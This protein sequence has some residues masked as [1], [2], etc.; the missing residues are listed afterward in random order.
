MTHTFRNRSRLLG[1]CASAAVA[2][3]L[4]LAPERAAA[5]GIQASGNVVL[6]S[7]NIVDTGPT[8]TQVSL[9]TPTVVI[10]WTPTEDVN[11]DA[12]DFI[13][14]GST[15]IFRSNVTP[16]F[17]VLNRILPSTNNNVMTID[18]SVLSQFISAVGAAST[19]GLVAFSSPT[20]IVIGNNAVF[21]I[22]RLLLT[23]HDISNFWFQNFASGGNLLLNG[24]SGTTA[25]VQ[26][27]PGAQITAAPE[28]AFFAVV[29]ADI[30][31]SG[32]SQVNGSQAFVVGEVVNL[33]FSNGLFNISVPVGTSASGQVLTVNGTVGGP[34]STGVTGDNHMIYGVAHAAADPISMLFSGNLGFDTAASAG[35]INGEI[36]LAANYDVFGRS[37]AGGTISD[38]IGATFRFVD[39]SSNIRADILVQDFNS[40]SSLLAVGTHAVDATAE[41]AN[42]RVDGNLLLVGRESASLSG[43]F[44][45]DFTVTGD[46]L[47]DARDYGVVSSS[48][49][50]I[51][52]A[53]AQGGNASIEADFAG[54]ITITGNALVTADAFGGADDINRI[55]GSA[56][57]GNASIGAN[58]TG[59]VSIV[60]SAT[61]S[62][63][64]Q[65]T[66]AITVLQGALARGGSARLAS[67]LFGSVSVGGD[68]AI[69]ADALGANGSTVN[70]STASNAFGGTAEINV[71]DLSS[72]VIGGDAVLNADAVGGSS[73]N[74]GAGSIG[75]AGDAVFSVVG[76]AASALVGNVRLAVTGVA[77]KVELTA[78]AFGG[79]N[80]GGVGGLATGGTAIVLAADSGSIDFRGEFG[81]EALGV[82]GN[83]RTGGE[84]FGGIG[85]VLAASGSIDI[86][87]NA[88]ADAEG[89][90]GFASFGFGGIGGLGQ[91]GSAFFQANGNEIDAASLTIGGNAF[92]T[93]QGVGGRGGDTDGDGIPGGDGGVGRGG[94]ASVTNQANEGFVSGAYILADADYGTI[95][96]GGEAFT[97]AR[98]FGGEGGTGNLLNLGGRGGDGFGGDAALGVAVLIA[99][100]SI[101][102]GLAEFGTV[103]ARA[104]GLG[105]AGGGQN[106]SG[107]VNIGDGGTGTAG[108]AGL[109]ADVGTVNVLSTANATNVTLEAVGFGG[110]GRQG[111][112]AN[113]GTATIEGS[114]GG[115]ITATGVIIDARAIGG[116]SGLDDPG[117]A[118]GNAFGGTARIT[119]SDASFVFSGGVQ[120]RADASGGASNNAGAGSVGDAGRAT[121]EVLGPGLIDVSGTVRLEAEGRGGNNASG[122]GGVGLGGRAFT[123]IA[124]GG[125][126]IFRSNYSADT[127]GFGGDG[128]TGG[129]GFG[130]AAGAIVVA[131]QLTITGNAFAGSEGNGGEA[132]SGFGGNGGFGSGGLSLF[133]ANGPLTETATISIGGTAVAF[134]QGVGGRGGDGLSPPGVAPGRGGD[135]RGGQFGVP[136]QADTN[137]PNSGAYIVAGGDNGNITVTGQ[138]VLVA[139]AYA[140]NGG[141]GSGVAGG[142]GGDA[143]GGLALA[144]LVLLGTDGSLGLGTADFGSVLVQSDAFGGQ[145][146][147]T[148][149]VRTGDG[150]IGTGGFGG[151]AVNAG[152]VTAAEIEITLAGTGG[153][154]RQG[155]T[156]RGGNGGIDGTLGGSITAT[157][158]TVAATGFGGQ[159]G[160][161]ASTFAFGN[162]FGGEARI[163]ANG[164]SLVANGNV[165]LDASATGGSMQGAAQG[166][167]GRAGLAFIRADGTNN[168]ASVNITGHTSIFANGNG[169]SALN[170]G[171]G[172]D[173]QGGIAYVDALAGGDVAL[174]SVQVTA[175]GRGG[176]STNSL[177]GA[178]TG[179]EVRLFASGT[180]SS[181]DV[182]RN[183]PLDFALGINSF[184]MLNANG[185]AAAHRG[186]TMIGAEGRGGTLAIRATGG[187]AILLPT[188]SDIANDPDSANGLMGFV[189]RGFGA[190]SQ[191]D[192][193]TAGNGFGGTG[194]IEVTAGSQ[195]VIGPNNFSVFGQGGSSTLP[196]A[197]VTGGTGFG[198]TRSINVLGGSQLTFQ[199]VAGT[200]GGLG[201]N[202]S[203]TGN[204]GFARG[205]SNSVVLTDSTL[206]IIGRMPV[207]DQSIGGNGVVG[208]LVLAGAPGS[209]VSF[210]ANNS[211]INISL[212]G[213]GQA[214]ILLTGTSSGG[215]GT[216]QGGSVVSP[217]TDLTL[218]D[219]Q[220][221]GGTLNVAPIA[222]GGNAS[223]ATG[224]GGDALNG[225][226]QVSVTGSSTGSDLLLSGENL[227]S[228]EARGGAGGASGQGGSAISGDVVVNVASSSIGVTGDLRVRSIATGGAGGTV[229]NATSGDASLTLAAAVVAATAQV[230]VAARA[231]AQGSAGQT[232]GIANA[233]EA[234]LSMDGGG[235]LDAGAILIDAT[236]LTSLGGAARGGFAS[237]IVGSDF[238]HIL[239]ATDLTLQADGEGADS[240]IPDNGAGQFAITVGSGSNVN[241]TNLTATAQGDTII[242]DPGP[243]LIGVF[244]G[245]LNVTN[246]LTATALDDIT[247]TGTGLIGEA[248]IDTTTTSIF[249]SSSGTVR[250]QE[251]G[252]GILSIGG[253]TISL[254]AGRSILIDGVLESNDGTIGLF[255][256]IGSSPSS[257]DPAEITMSAGASLD[258]G[259]GSV[260]IVMDSG[261]PS[262]GIT[263]SNITA[264][265]IGVRNFGEDPGSDITVLSSG[266]LT[267]SGTGRAID[268]ASLNGEV[269]NLHG[270]AGLILTGGG[271]FGIFAATPS[272][273]QIGSFAN[274][275]RRYNV[276]NDEEYDSLNP[277]GNF[278]AFRFAPTLTVT[279][280][281]I[282][283]FY[284]DNV[285]ALTASITGFLPGD[286][287]ADLLGS[288]E[289]STLADSTSNVG[290]YDIIAAIGTLVSEQGYQFDFAPGTLTVTPRPITVTADSLP[291]IYG[292]A[293]PPLTFTVGGLGLVNGDQLTGELATTA[294][295][296]TNVGTA[297]ITQGT[298][299]ASPNY[300]VTFVD[301]LLTITPR[302]ITVT[303]NDLSRIYGDANPPLTFTV[304]GLGLVNG[305][306]LTGELAT[307]ADPTTNVGTAAITQGT[308]AASPNYDV[309]FVDGL[310]TI[311]PRAITVT[312][313]SL[314]RIYGN[315]NPALT[316]SVGGLGL[317][318]GDQITGALTTT[319][320]ATTGV[321]N[322]AITQGTIGAS[323]N[324]ALTFV[325]GALTITPRPITV[326][327][328]SLS[329]IY[330]NT[331]PALT[332]TVGGLGLVNGD[333]IAG[334]LT[335]TA[336]VTTGVGNVAITQGTIG[337][338]SNYALTFVNGALTITPRAI[339]VTADDLSRFYGDA[340]P[341]L[342]FSVGGL[343]LVNGDQITG[344]LNT[345]ANSTTGVGSVAI[346]Q[347]TL[348]TSSNY[349]LTFVNGTLAITPR[350]ITITAD[351]LAKLLGQEDP[352]LTFS[353][354]G[355]GLVNGD[356][357]SGGLVRDEGEMPGTLAIQLGSLSAGPN[358]AATFVPGTFTIK[359][360]PTPSEVTNTTTLEP[361]DSVE[362]TPPPP[363]SE[364]EEEE[365]FGMDFPSQPDAQLIAEDA[366]LDE[367]VA[368]G[369]D[370]SLYGGSDVPVTGGGQ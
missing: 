351:D 360:P 58:D 72:L 103:R 50:T 106:V 220:I 186:G 279:A 241:L 139:Q 278:A 244:D 364:E 335:T 339:T 250:V 260:S 356:T 83:G 222:Q 320:N 370:A 112:V 252:S 345:A 315:T 311:T 162:A 125:T 196:S 229:G 14:T 297:A 299:A 35:V 93:V 154:G 206:D 363:P 231:I 95:T 340:N 27:N 126:I 332:F 134:A 212:D 336:D 172:G 256:N 161:D 130:G 232:G 160:P 98:G 337:A 40:N 355:L 200:T 242:G 144:G 173:G 285:P 181:I 357:F 213:L 156:G 36:I 176:A 120:L 329:R 140:G 301:G 105:G 20:G 84:G 59:S 341:A 107:S 15:G 321:G 77:G 264:G 217:D 211:L 354:G 89:F 131:G 263:V 298:L 146:G 235:T 350:P 283:Q 202:G 240:A 45:R 269:I 8:T 113:G 270:D 230:E 348:G 97:E 347:G 314:S 295:P 151:V 31:M 289:L 23:T 184:F 188:E 114:L 12:L 207:I 19:A 190:G 136:N 322:V 216:S 352:A 42:S 85:G 153:A 262:G 104:D 253:N 91:G 214:G 166:G 198:G 203:G 87:G 119:A 331:N 17:A 56:V 227:F 218:I 129:A 239:Q 33:S 205:G 60:G 334:A 225:S 194:L 221:I 169:G 267:A 122:V 22:G 70:P 10:D 55:A 189:A 116:F 32:N 64:G 44:G 28:N 37:V 286:S 271:H 349:A 81:S 328:N 201:G 361:A 57:G 63:R 199:G 149:S 290:L 71:N 183:V 76:E 30:E 245:N 78:Q 115:G 368:S 3:A 118:T 248:P 46:V 123:E 287:I 226:L 5:Q 324:Y 137:L 102:A 234:L 133:Q 51:D 147:F 304:G 327:A 338:S 281:D 109:T 209:G 158:I 359:A 247:L 282:A 170:L 6:G 302:A 92:A 358:Y 251:D 344:A 236:A 80:A 159:S 127:L 121:I 305:D 99:D 325:N 333:Q 284:G 233:G 277:G 215:S 75:D 300:D 101:G 150:G 163:L 94:N 88:S 193:G 69:N 195:I 246:S 273:S 21:D 175:V 323:S 280:D 53:N 128:Q 179:G 204:G 49:S 13:P 197:N 143:L 135:A 268:L 310:L 223:S 293:N 288:P 1:G 259:T 117:I 261:F 4:I 24:T 187:G 165:L 110:F 65:G 292:D 68:V 73:N 39:G 25:R 142:N 291:R 108:A 86:A 54:S 185:F 152:T 90:G 224:I 47:V 16:D 237:L 342:T 29:A 182:A 307:T 38:G 255:A 228:A 219:T 192:L 254:N 313:N 306:Q 296:T 9:L 316:F 171:I 167:R 346:T 177:G 257:L 157:D 61:I 141:D 79:A 34:S 48:L 66:T 155:G 100:G 274:Y 272:G 178:G 326:T 343:G 367:P 174:G 168:A 26:I 148:G 7:A 18:G 164:M 208:G 303:A 258:A 312:A 238:P 145:G 210:F 366:L 249:V 318:N 319:A 138:A 266:V 353:V 191:V 52:E 96:V 365:V 362:D 275:V 308:L 74:A 294:D 180:G 82:G 41:G 309:T 2:L 243:S 317:V 67:T 11:G 43:L 265:T 330:G 62:A 369:G 124:D 132:N 276:G 111:G